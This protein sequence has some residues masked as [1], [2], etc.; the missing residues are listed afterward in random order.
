MIWTFLIFF[1]NLILLGLQRNVQKVADVTGDAPGL[2]TFDT[3]TKPPFRAAK[4]RTQKPKLCA[5]KFLA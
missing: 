1:S 2:Q 4:L 3:N 5:N